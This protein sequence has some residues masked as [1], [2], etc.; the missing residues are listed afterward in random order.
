MA[1]TALQPRPV[2][3]QEAHALNLLLAQR[4]EARRVALLRRM[5]AAHNA[6][7]SAI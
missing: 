3:A 7:G 4:A 6:D 2:P 5:W 1:I